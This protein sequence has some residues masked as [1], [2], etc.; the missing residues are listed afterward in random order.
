M[1]LDYRSDG[2]SGRKVSGWAVTSIACAV[3]LAVPFGWMCQTMVDA[4]RMPGHYFPL[5]VFSLLFWIVAPLS[6]CGICSGLAAFRVGGRSRVVG[7][8]GLILSTL[9]LAGLI[10][11]LVISRG[12]TQSP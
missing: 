1:K 8:V 7:S 2:V 10:Y 9:A 5:L 3:V 11:L 4:H 6:A 12:G